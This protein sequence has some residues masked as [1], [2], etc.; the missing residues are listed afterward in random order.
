METNGKAWET[1]KIIKTGK[2]Y[3]RKWFNY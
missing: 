3:I 2:E 1:D